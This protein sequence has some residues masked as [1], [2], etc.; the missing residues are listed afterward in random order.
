MDQRDESRGFFNIQKFYRSH[1]PEV[2]RNNRAL[3][4]GLREAG[5]LTK[6]ETL[7]AE[8]MAEVPPPDRLEF[9]NQAFRPLLNREVALHEKMVALQKAHD[10]LMK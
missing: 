6:E 8:K 9:W 4:D 5:S 7:T 10:A 2:A 3:V 1:S